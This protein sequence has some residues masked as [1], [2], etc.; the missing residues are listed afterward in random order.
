MEENW[1]CLAISILCNCT[2]E[3][4]EVIYEFGKNRK[5][6]PRVKLEQEDLEGMRKHREEGLTWKQVG[7]LF[8]LSE[9]GAFK[10][11]KR[12]EEDCKMQIQA[13]TYIVAERV[14]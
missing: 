11:F 13:S 7:D 4:A 14:S 5:Q 9:S 3:Q 8:G 12:Y 10:R 2:P 6:K 1:C